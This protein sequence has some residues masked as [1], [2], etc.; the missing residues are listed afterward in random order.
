MMPKPIHL[1]CFLILSVLGNLSCNDDNGN[2]VRILPYT[3]SWEIPA[4]LNN[5]DTHFF[6]FSNIDNRKDEFFGGD[7]ALSEIQNIRARRADLLLVGNNVSFNEVRSVE[8]WVY[9]I[10]DEE[11]DYEVFYTLDL[12][13]QSGRQAISLIPSLSNIIDLYQEDAFRLEVRVNFW[14]VSSINLPV[15]MEWEFEAIE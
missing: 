9:G 12:R 10:E 8:V 5:F 3:V 2:V 11:K 1:F 13:N 6:E 7:L 15:R 14:T 4:G